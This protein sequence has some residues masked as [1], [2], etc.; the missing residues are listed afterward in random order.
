MHICYLMV[1]VKEQADGAVRGLLAHALVVLFLCLRTTWATLP[2]PGK[3]LCP[4]LFLLL[5]DL[6]VY[7]HVYRCN[8]GT[9]GHLGF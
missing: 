9:K 5:L 3:W 1:S 4:L 8:D 6:Y 7:T 2:Q